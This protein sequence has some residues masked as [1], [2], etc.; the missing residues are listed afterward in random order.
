[1][2]T[3]FYKVKILLTAKR[4][5]IKVGKR[6]ARCYGAEER[7]EVFRN[8]VAVQINVIGPR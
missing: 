3:A 8:V 5:A 1:M 4:I 2:S 7:R 6:F